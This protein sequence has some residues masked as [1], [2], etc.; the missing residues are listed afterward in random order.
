MKAKKDDETQVII[1]GNMKVA[2]GIW[3][4]WDESQ[5]PKKEAVPKKKE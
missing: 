3:V 5:K 1:R 2:G 4:P